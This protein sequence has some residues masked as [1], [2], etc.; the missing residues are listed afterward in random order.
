MKWPMLV[1][2]IYLSIGVGLLM[3]GLRM[4]V[5]AVFERAGRV[6]RHRWSGRR[7]VIGIVAI[8]LGVTMMA[9]A[10]DLI[11]ALVG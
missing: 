8:V 9:T 4:V 10:D 3:L 7:I 11:A 1:F 2:V 6:P 5:V